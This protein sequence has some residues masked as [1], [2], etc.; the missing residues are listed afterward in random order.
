VQGKLFLLAEHLENG[1][2]VRDWIAKRSISE[3]VD[4]MNRGSDP[5]TRTFLQSI[6]AAFQA[7]VISEAEAVAAAGSEAEF[8]RAARG[9]S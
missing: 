3:I 7:G 8:R 4:Y 9:I 5:N 2:A 6:V 1:G